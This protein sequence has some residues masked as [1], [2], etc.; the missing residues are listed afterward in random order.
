MNKIDKSKYFDSVS[1]KLIR[2][3]NSNMTIY[4]EVTIDL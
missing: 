1:Q 4:I 3:E 2:A